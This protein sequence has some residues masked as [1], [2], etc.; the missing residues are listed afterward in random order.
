MLSKRARLFQAYLDKLGLRF[1]VQELP[2]STRTAREAANAV[3][4][5]IGQIVKS[6]V[7][8]NAETGEPLVVLA[9]GPNR[10]DEHLLSEIAGGPVEFADAAFVR[11]MT[12]FAIGGVPPMGHKT[13]CRMIVDEDLY[14]YEEI[15]AAAGTP[16]A[17]FRITGDLGEILPQHAVGKLS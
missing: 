10:V 5:E 2:A 1:N 17:V 12:G 11:E 4:C 3:G 13:D 16:N 9:S 6:L 8:R 14:Q 7:F 15:W